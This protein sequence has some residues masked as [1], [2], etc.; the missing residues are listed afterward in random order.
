MAIDRTSKFTFARLVQKA[1][2][3]AAS[4]FLQ[5]LVEAMPYRIHTVLTDK[6]HPVRGPAQKQEW[7]DGALE[8]PSTRPRVLRH[9]IEHRLTKTT[10]LGQRAG[11][12]G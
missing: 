9:G 2:T 10:I 7:A 12:S 11:W 3:K 1:D 5:A 6:W 8:R 4:D